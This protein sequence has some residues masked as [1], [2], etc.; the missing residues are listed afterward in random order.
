[1]NKI[2]QATQLLFENLIDTN[3]NQFYIPPHALLRQSIAHYT[4]SLPA[5]N[6][7]SEYLTLIP[8]ASGCIVCTY[9]GKY[10]DC[11][12]WGPTTQT[13]IVKNDADENIFRFF[14]EFLPCGAYH[15]T[16]IDI[17]ELTDLQVPLSIINLPLA[18]SIDELFEQS[19]SIQELVDLLDK[20][21]LSCLSKIQ[22]TNYI[23]PILSYIQAKNG[24]MTVKE[25]S[26][27]TFYSERHLNRMITPILGMNVKSYSKL[28]RINTALKNINNDVSF[29]NLAQTLNYY[30]QSHFIHDFKSVCGVTPTAYLQNMSDFYK[31]DFKF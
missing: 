8:D 4:I 11:N 20:T 12:F 17:S 21:F 25:L 18:K 29:T 15:L 16:G 13:T 5:R 26:T 14:I 9:D 7:G 27:A 6:H 2:V 19:K 22:P 1:M 28:L 3:P 23:A 10:L 24:T 30:D 31:E